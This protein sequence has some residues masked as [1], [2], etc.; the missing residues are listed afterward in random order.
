MP[1]ACSKQHELSRFFRRDFRSSFA[2]EH[3]AEGIL[4]V[5]EEEHLHMARIRDEVANLSCI[6]LGLFLAP[7]VSKI[8]RKLNH[9]KAKVQ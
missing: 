9:F 5:R 3:L 4:L 8:D 2:L 6:A 1:L 7:R